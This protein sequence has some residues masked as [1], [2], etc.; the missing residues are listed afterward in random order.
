MTRCRL[1]K[2]T[3]YAA[4]ALVADGAPQRRHDGAV[5]DVVFE[6]RSHAV[7]KAEIERRLRSGKV[8]SRRLRA[9]LYERCLFPTAIGLDHIINATTHQ[10]AIPSVSRTSGFTFLPKPLTA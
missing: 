10:A 7:K 3:E 4:S 1:D 8:L 5:V 6:Q 9:S 2:P